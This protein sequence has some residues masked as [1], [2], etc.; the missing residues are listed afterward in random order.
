MKYCKKC[1]ATVRGGHSLCPLCQGPLTGEPEGELWPEIPT[2]YSRYKLFFKIVGAA[3][4]AV[5]ILSVAVNLML[6]QSGNWSLFVVFGIACLWVSL[7]IAIQ[8]RHKIPRNILTQVVLVSVL[9]VLWDLFTGWHRW[10]L[11]YVIPLLCIAAM[12]SLAI[13]AKVL[14]M[15][16]EDYLF[17][18]LMD[19]IFGIVPLVFYFTHLLTIIYPSILCAALSLVSFVTILIFN[20]RD[21]FT[22]LGKRFHI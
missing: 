2:V 10:S 6:P 18:L 11:D 20:G 19:C 8:K 3:S 5:G 15:P 21:V 1:G 14:H 22:E 13:L 7:W 12:L 16:A 17:S 4:A 9:C